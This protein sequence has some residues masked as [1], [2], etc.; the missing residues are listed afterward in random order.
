MRAGAGRKII[1]CELS[2]DGCK[3]WRLGDIHRAAP[4]NQFG[5]HWAWVFWEISIPLSAHPQH[6]LHVEMAWT[7][8]F[9]FPL[10]C[11]RCAIVMIVA[12]EED[13]RSI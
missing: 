8:L 12:V 1:R 4:P 3:T 7:W 9:A 5:K 13:G 11:I 2:V 6:S 10:A